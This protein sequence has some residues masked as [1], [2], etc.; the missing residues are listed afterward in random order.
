[1][2]LLNG[3]KNRESNFK[4][5]GEGKTYR[6]TLQ[7]FGRKK[8]NKQRVAVILNNERKRGKRKRA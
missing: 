6:H 4:E 1:M 3:K 8:A 2:P 5:F 7:K